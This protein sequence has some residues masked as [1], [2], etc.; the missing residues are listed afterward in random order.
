MD[1]LQ[2][3]EA[4][5]I[6]AYDDFLYQ[7]N[8]FFLDNDCVFLEDVFQLFCLLFDN[9]NLSIKQP[10]KDTSYP[11]LPLPIQCSDGLQV[12][13]GVCCCRH[14]NGLFYDL[15][16]SF[17]KDCELSYIFIDENNYWHKKENGCGANHVVVTA[18][19]RNTNFLFDVFNNYGFTVTENGDLHQLNSMKISDELINDYDD[20]HNVTT[21]SKVLT[22]Y[23]HLRDLGVTHLYEN[24]Q[25]GQ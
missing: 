14:I 6:E 20:S 12:M 15:L 4:L 22:K 7:L 19:E 24:E 13:L 2:K 5:L 21:I 10:T 8:R 23:Y 1:F 9:G 3:D 11:Y 17:H 25:Y 16:K 18:H